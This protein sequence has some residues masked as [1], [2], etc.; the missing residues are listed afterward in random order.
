M[1]RILHARAFHEPLMNAGLVPPHCKLMDVI[2]GVDGAVSVVYEAFL[3]FDQ[4]ER[5]ATVLLDVARREGKP[6]GAAT[7]TD[8]AENHARATLGTPGANG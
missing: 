5:L 8:Q 3:D 4:I 1:A 2:I 6:H 7:G